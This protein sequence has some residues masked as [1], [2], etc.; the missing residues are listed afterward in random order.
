MVR[1]EYVE[2]KVVCRFCEHVFPVL[3]TDATELTQSGSI[4]DTMMIQTH[5]D[6]AEQFFESS[7]QFVATFREEPG[8]LDANQYGPRLGVEQLTSESAEV[9]AIERATREA[10]RERQQ[11]ARRHAE[12]VAEAAHQAQLAELRRNDEDARLRAEADLKAEC[13]RWEQA[14][15]KLASELD[16]RLL[17]R[18]A[19][20]AEHEL[21]LAILRESLEADRRKAFEQ[22]ESARRKGEGEA[23]AL[24]SRLDRLH[25]DAKADARLRAER[26]RQL[27]TLKADLAQ[28]RREAVKQSKA[29]EVLRNDLEAARAEIAGA[30]AAFEGER[31]AAAAQHDRTREEAESLRVERDKAL[32]ESDALAHASTMLQRA[33]EEAEAAAAA[34]AIV[35]AD[36]LAS[37]NAELAKSHSA[38]SALI[39]RN[40]ALAHE[41]AALRAELDRRAVA[42]ADG[43]MNLLPVL[44]RDL[45]RWSLPAPELSTASAQPAAVMVATG[46]LPLP[47][48]FG[49]LTAVE[50]YVE[51]IRG[52]LRTPLAAGKP[53]HTHFDQ[54][55]LEVLQSKLCEAQLLADR[56]L[57]R[58]ERSRN[59][60]DLMWHLMV[61][62]RTDELNRKRR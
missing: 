42:A 34:T 59:T 37:V 50:Q 22:T 9:L 52:L 46:P 55:R 10:E 40:A 35:H 24:Q 14:S 3:P 58:V 15:Q 54:A 38:R 5:G 1:R 25:A 20:R 57:S 18:E 43:R 23:L 56:L 39:D 31:L 49:D 28:L 45:K 61:A 48:S 51:M 7:M 44:L 17:E 16:R 2:Q 53:Y 62:Q 32:A 47:P 11:A 21:A 6:E 36:A 29:L 8:R 26:D 19:E 13:D 41:V 27:G 12:S 4:A 33:V 60:K 30:S